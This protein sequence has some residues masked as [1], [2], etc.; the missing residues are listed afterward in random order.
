MNSSFMPCLRASS[1]GNYSRNPPANACLGTDGGTHPRSLRPQLRPSPAIASHEVHAES[2]HVCQEV[3]DRVNLNRGAI[4]EDLH[5]GIS[6]GE[7]NG[8]R[9]R[10]DADSRCRA[11]E[12]V[13]TLPIATCRAF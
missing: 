3:C 9:G 7:V 12:D 2:E 11:D 10:N 4:S 8:D 13:D 6:T 5:L 1:T